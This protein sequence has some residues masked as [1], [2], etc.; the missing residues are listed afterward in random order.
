MVREFFLDGLI[1]ALSTS[2]TKKLYLAAIR[3]S[4]TLHSKFA[5]HSLISGSLTR[6]AGAGVR[7]VDFNLSTLAGFYWPLGASLFFFR[8]SRELYHLHNKKY[9][10]D[11]E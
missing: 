5:K 9:P 1:Q 2:R 7:P 6:A 4:M 11:N 10:S 8:L 3:E